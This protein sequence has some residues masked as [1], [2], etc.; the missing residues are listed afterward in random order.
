MLND[1]QEILSKDVKEVINSPLSIKLL[2]IYSTIYLGGAQPRWC[3]KSQTSYY[4]QIAIDGIKKL[5]AMKDILN[6]TCEL[7]PDMMIFSSQLAIHITNANITDRIACEGLT[8]GFLKESQFI[9]LPDCWV[10]K[11][12]VKEPIEDDVSEKENIVLET[13]QPTT[14]RIETRGRKSKHNR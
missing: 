5:N 13:V 2:K 4:N 9:K 14:Q 8:K 3:A 10:N 1:I 12:E 7:K 6:R 11:N